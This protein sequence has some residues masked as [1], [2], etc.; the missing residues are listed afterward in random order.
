MGAGLDGKVAVVTGAAG[1]LGQAIVLELLTCGAVPVL[2]D[3]P[4]RLGAAVASITARTGT[5]PATLPCDVADAAQVE[6]AAAGLAC[7]VLVNNAAILRQAPLREHPL[8]VWDSVLA[9]NLRGYFVCTQA[10][11]RG[12]LSR[13]GGSIVNVASLAA[14]R[15][16]DANG[17]YCASKAG[18]LALTRQTALEWG[19]R[20]IRANA[21][22]PTFMRTPMT[23]GA[24]DAE[25]RAGLVALGRVGETSEIASV[26]SFLAGAESSYLNGVDLP[27]DGGA[28]R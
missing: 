24:D 14:G 2:L 27:V 22:S 8:D 6:A 19:P 9:V 10:F 13:G 3:L 21:V 18:I 1:G 5:R 15:A 4:D 12:M 28:R 26:V 7:D 16:S 11:G 20:G 23:D 25:R 17:A